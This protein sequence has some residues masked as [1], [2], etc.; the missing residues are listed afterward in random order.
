VIAPGASDDTVASAGAGGFEALALD[1]S[2]TDDASDGGIRLGLHRSGPLPILELDGFDLLLSADPSAPR[3]WVGLPAGELD[4]A[5]AALQAAVSRTPTTALVL[6]QVLRM[7]LRLPFDD[8]LVAES[9]AY[10][11]LLGGAEFQAWRAERPAR[12]ART[13]PDEAR[14]RLNR[15]GGNLRIT[16]ARPGARNAVDA[17]MRD[18]LVEALDFAL[19]DPD[20]APVILSGEG[21]SF[22]AGGDLDEFGRARD[23]AAA[24]MIRTRQ[25]AA[26]LV[27]RLGSRITARLH[28]ACIGAG[29]EIPAAAGRVT[30]APDTRL[31]L[32]EVSMGLIP[33]AGGTVTIP[34]RIGRRRACYMAL[35]G[36]V[37]DAATALRWGLI[38]AVEAP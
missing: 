5:V 37:I 38:D 20:M 22:S 10:S 8:A 19:I 29:I 33:G 27:H 14:V 3:P 9:L 15:E 35:S 17:G 31:R 23:L 25:S 7:S 30:A 1:A 13:G 2:H 16:L 36:R 34:R 21:P 11:M 12:P 18:A 26:R 4:D 28:G 6:A 24:H 32:P